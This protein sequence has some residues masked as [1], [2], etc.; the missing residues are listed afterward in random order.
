MAKGA[1]G[2]GKPGARATRPSGAKRPGGGAPARVALGND[3]FERG[4]AV[5]VQLA[6]ATPSGGARLPDSP[7]APQVRAS[8]EVTREQAAALAPDVFPRP[9]TVPGPVAVDER[10]VREARPPGGLAGLL[11]QLWPALR[12]RLAPVLSLRRLFSNPALPD[13]HGMDPELV[14]RSSPVFDFL[15]DA[16]WRVEV[17]GL[18]QL[19]PGPALLVA[20]HGGRFHWDALVLAHVLRRDQRRCR[21]LLDEHALAIP[22]AG[23]IVTRL[24][25]VLA[26][27]EHALAL[28]SEGSLV[29]VFPEGSRSGNREWGDRYQIRRFGR[30][31]FAHIALRAR[32]PVVPCAIVGGEE[33]SAPFARPGWLAEALGIPL[34]GAARAL[35]LGPLAW[36]PLPS[37]WTVRFGDPIAPEGDPDDPQSVDA[38]TEQT[39]ATLQR[40]LDQDVA[41]RKSVY[42]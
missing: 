40:M 18:E 42:L 9:A 2:R 19:P 29:A 13:R 7:P 30:G 25:A 21:S 5:A 35:P 14:A 10:P 17:R 28:L 8:P 26:S 24:G 15:L 38:L 33:T 22:L 4:A 23:R 34:L 32:A 39:R 27:P 11:R 37:R 36:L 20:N 3:P 16:W 41:R 31:G 12:A 1:G 6:M